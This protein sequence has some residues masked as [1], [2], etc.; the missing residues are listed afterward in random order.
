VTGYG[1]EGSLFESTL[2]ARNFF[3][4]L[5]DWPWGSPNFLNNGCRSSVLGLKR[6]W[7]DVSHPHPF[8]AEV[9]NEWSYTS[10]PSLCV[11][12]YEEGHTN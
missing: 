12:H 9:K 1:L 6:K 11:V 7:C 5:P 8:S 3:R 2:K 10:T 4:T